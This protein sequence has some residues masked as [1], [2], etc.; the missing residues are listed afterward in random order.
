MTCVLTDSPRILAFL[1]PLLPPA[2]HL[3]DLPLTLPFACELNDVVGGADDLPAAQRHLV[4]DAEV[5]VNGRGA[6]EG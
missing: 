4:C 3:L 6:E 5:Q 1:V 2:L